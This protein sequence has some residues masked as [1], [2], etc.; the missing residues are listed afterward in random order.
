MQ[1][2][3][4]LVAEKHVTQFVQNDVVAMHRARGVLDRDEV[5]VVKGHP[6]TARHF[7]GD[8]RHG[9][10]MYRP[11]AH[12]GDAADEF[13]RAERIRYIELVQN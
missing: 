12:F 8:T 5:H 9:F 13:V 6:E 3:S 2:L 7:R 11:A 1:I 4:G 10:E